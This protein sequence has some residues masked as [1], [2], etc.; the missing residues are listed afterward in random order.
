MLSRKVDIQDFNDLMSAKTD[1]NEFIILNE[2]IKMLHK[3][4]DS[5][6]K[7]L[8]QQIKLKVTPLNIEIENKI[9]KDLLN[10]I[11]LLKECVDEF[12]PERVDAAFTRD[13]VFANQRQSMTT[14]ANHL[15]PVEESTDGYNNTHTHNNNNLNNLSS[16]RRQSGYIKI[17]KF[18]S[19][20][21]QWCQTS[22]NLYGS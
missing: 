10:Q 9:C 17:R 11:V 12:D 3:M 20:E 8:H 5:F 14:N 21:Q 22:R 13:A 18:I 4:T 2:H 7:I 15:Q 6:A 19:N 1:K 16:N